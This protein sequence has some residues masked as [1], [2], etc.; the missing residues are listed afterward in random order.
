MSTVFQKGPSMKDMVMDF[1]VIT[2][3]QVRAAS[4]VGSQLGLEKT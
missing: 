4:L 3:Y 1:T 2:G